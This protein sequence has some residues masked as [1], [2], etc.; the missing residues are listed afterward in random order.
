MSDSIKHECGVTLLRL[1]QPLSHYAGTYGP[2]ASGYAELSLLFDIQPDAD[3][4]R[5]SWRSLCYLLWNAYPC[6]AWMAAYDALADVVRSERSLCL[7]VSD[8]DT[9]RLLIHLAGCL[10]RFSSGSV[11]LSVCRALE[12]YIS[13]MRQP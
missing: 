10:P 11:Y 4:D 3:D 7:G 12:S 8:D 5:P 13:L 2:A 9:E 1:R 6:D